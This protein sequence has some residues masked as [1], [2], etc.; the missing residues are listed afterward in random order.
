MTYNDLLQYYRANVPQDPAAPLGTDAGNN[1]FNTWTAQLERELGIPGGDYD[2]PASGWATIQPG[3]LDEFEV[4]G[5]GGTP[6]T[7]VGVE[8]GIYNRALPGLL[9]DIDADTGRR[10]LA[11]TLA[12]SAVQGTQAATTQLQRTQGGGF[13]GR[14]YLAQNPDVAEAFERER[15]ANPRADINEFAERHFL[16]NGQREGRTPAYI[17]SAQLAQDMNNAN[18]T[19]DANIAA[20]NRAFQTNLTALTDATTAMQ[21]NLSG[22]LAA[23]AAALQ[24]QITALNQNLDTLDAAQ[25][26][27]LTDQIASMQ[28]NLEQAVATQ[29]Q[30]L[31]DQVRALGTAATTE[32]AA[33]RAALQTEIASLTAAQAPLAE[34]R[35]KAAELQ[36]TAVNVGLEQTRDQLAADQARAGYVGGS[37]FGD[38][39]LARATVGAR[40]KA[41]EAVSGARVANAGDMRE[42]NVRGATGERSIAD[43]FAA[44]QREIAGL[45]ATGE[46]SL[47]D[48]FANE[49]RRLGDGSATGLAAIA[50]QTARDRAGIGAQGANTTFQDQIFGANQQRTIADALATGTLGLRGTLAGQTLA[51]ERAGNAARANYYDNDYSR[52]L[53]ASLALTQLPGNLTQSL[54]GLDNYAQSGMGRTLNT[55]N[56][57]NTG[58]G[59]PPTPGANAVN[60]DTTGNSLSGLGSGIF[61]AALNAGN[62]NRWWAPTRRPANPVTPPNEALED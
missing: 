62:A 20:A 31:Q 45:S 10:T 13:D 29:R 16:T 32:T 9:A 15:L 53:S 51:D 6:A 46:R 7:N 14:T 11:D 55:L 47:T 22:N 1:R 48:S 37:T 38:A 59:A 54:T 33:R 40:Q 52:S 19:T 41:G 36:A 18:V 49:R 56:W 61:G 60:A 34:A 24:Q 43:A 42:I 5:G 57:W 8:Q 27:A 26:R 3:Q 50:N 30:A 39:S 58:A 23:R 4:Q 25:R 44:A 35:L 21:G 28:A 2:D 12:A 17:Q